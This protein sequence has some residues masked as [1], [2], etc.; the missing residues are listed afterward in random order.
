MAILVGRQRVLA[1]RP[2]TC[3]RLTVWVVND[4]AVVLGGLGLCLSVGP[5]I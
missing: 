4:F 1:I 3:S 2:S 5:V